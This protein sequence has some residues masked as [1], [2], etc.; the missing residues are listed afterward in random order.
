VEGGR[1]ESVC[2]REMQRGRGEEESVCERERSR[3][4]GRE[5]R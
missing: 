2:I 1:R 4:G 5:E 3:E